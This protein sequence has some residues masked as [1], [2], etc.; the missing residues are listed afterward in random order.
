MREVRK[1][2]PASD[3]EV[4]FRGVIQESE[5]P[6][7]R[8]R[9][10]A[11]VE[12][13][14]ELFKADA[15]DY[16]Q[17]TGVV[18][19]R[20]HVSYKNFEDGEE[21]TCDRLD[22][23]LKDRQGTFYKIEGTFPVKIDPRPGILASSRPFAFKGRYAERQGNKYLLYD[24]TLTNCD[25]KSP[26][27]EL[28]A[29]KFDIIPKERA[30][31]YQ[32]FLK[33]FRLPILYVPAFY[34]SLEERPRRSGFLTPTLGNSNRRGLMVGGGYY[35]AINRS[36]DLQYRGQYFTQRGLAH[37]AE[38]R[39]KPTSRSDFD[40]IFY[41]VQDR[42]LRQDDGS[43]VKQGGYLYSAR[44]T[45][46]I[47]AGFYA[48]ANVNYLSSY[49]FRQAFTENFNEAVFS[50]VNSTGNL[51]KDWSSYHFNVVATRHQNFM[52]PA[53]NSSIVIRKIPQVEFNSRDRELKEG[54]PV[55]VSWHTSGGLV[56]RTQAL[57]QT[58][59]VVQRLDA[60]PRI[61]TAVRWKEISL[62]P[63]F[64]VRQT[65]YGS[66][67]RDGKITGHD[68][69]RSSREFQAD[70][71]LPTLEK[72][73][74]APAWMGEKLKHSIETRAS[75]KHVSGV[76]NFAELVRFDEME[77]VANTN[78]L[79]VMV[80]NRLWSKAKSGAVWDVLSW[81]V[82]QRRYFSP[83][84]GGAVMPGERNVFLAS[85][86]M[87]AYTFFDQVRRQSPY[88]SGVRFSPRPGVGLDWRN[89][90]DPVRGKLVNNSISLD[91]RKEKYFLS[92]GH[93]YVACI[94]LQF[95]PGDGGVMVTP[96][97]LE[98]PPQGSVLTPTANQ[99]RGMLGFGDENKRGWNTAFLAVYDYRRGQMQYANTQITYNTACC[100]FSG[101]YRRLAF[102]TRNENQYRFAFVIANLGSFGTLRRQERLF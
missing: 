3:K 16:N 99:F 85:E 1:E 19:A 66:S 43:R 63:S 34:K 51:S 54:W 6:R 102:G 87:T 31:A 4:I 86:E 27:W 41:G 52:D 11:E 55:W 40:A 2:G 92:V 69:L 35:W 17:E 13:T 73:F 50:E 25:P 91:A 47:G 33:L 65:Y 61:S 37:H 93:S 80:A 83:S 97:G 78:E 26:T 57:Y 56:R 84:M 24:G 8:L 46:D 59:Q 39:G 101:Q 81:E 7:K 94:P 82:S 76:R 60:E 45:I 38:L 29:P 44:G 32:T 30:I 18:E 72:V 15:I 58:R 74:A 48:R 21:I 5:G 53:G 62:I 9:Q 20:G 77:L 49:V 88:V 95:I 100:A 10:N 71:I 23:N 89:D 96:C 68:R 36:Y 67:F 79:E 98:R 14:K 70:L 28:S 75:F 22:Y 64:S 42:G 12:T 90:F